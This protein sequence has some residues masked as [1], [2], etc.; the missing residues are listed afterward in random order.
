[1]PFHLPGFLVGKPGR[2]LGEPLRPNSFLLAKVRKD[3]FGTQEARKES[4]SNENRK[5]NYTA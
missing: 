3:K 1:M 4:G 5:R 2:S